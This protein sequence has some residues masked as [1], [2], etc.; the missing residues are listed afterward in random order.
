MVRPFDDS[1]SDDGIGYWGARSECI[2]DVSTRARRQVSSKKYDSEIQLANGALT[3]SV[4]TLSS[5]IRILMNQKM[6][7]DEEQRRVQQEEEGKK[8][9]ELSGSSRKRAAATVKEDKKS[10]KKAKKK[11]AAS[12]SD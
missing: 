6:A 11:E 7:R 5:E 2:A 12:D 3:T 1:D 8:E 4:K 10:R 9:K